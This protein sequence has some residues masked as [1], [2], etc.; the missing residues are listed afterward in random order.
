MSKYQFRNK[1]PN[2]KVKNL[3]IAC[4]IIFG[5][6]LVFW[7]FFHVF[8]GFGT[9]K[10]KTYK[11]YIKRSQAK[12]Y[13][14][15]IPQDAEDF[16]FESHNYGLVAFSAVGFTLHG[17]EYDDFVNGITQNMHGKVV[18]YLEMGK[19]LDYTGLK[20]SE[21]VNNYDRYQNY[22]GFPTKAHDDVIFDYV[23]DDNIMDYT[24]LYYD[25]YEGAGERLNTIAT[26]PAT[27]RIIIYDYGSN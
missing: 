17:Q 22:I 25:F 12:F 4:S 20:V 6:I 5:I 9:F 23:T 3:L 13:H 19:E 1:Q 14:N 15:S 18:G 21:T 11:S 24:I 16:R 2:K 7:L 26:N 27:G 8:M 10:G